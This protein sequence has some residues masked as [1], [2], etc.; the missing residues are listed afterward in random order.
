MTT[1]PY[2]GLNL[3]SLI[4]LNGP[5][6]LKNSSMALLLGEE[7]IFRSVTKRVPFHKVSRTIL[8]HMSHRIPVV[9]VH[10]ILRQSEM[11]ID[12]RPVSI[13]STDDLYRPIIECM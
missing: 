13:R 4:S 10:V 7:V 6:A 9:L 12:L 2:F 8:C 5:Q 3:Q 1:N 11:N